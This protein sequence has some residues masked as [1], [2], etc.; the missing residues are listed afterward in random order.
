VKLVIVGGGFAGVKTALELANNKDFEIILISER[1]NFEYHGALY[2]SGTGR[3]PLE[4]VL[5][6]RDIIKHARNVT[7]VQDRIVGLD[8][9]K[10]RIVSETG[11]IYG[12]DKLVLALGNVV[13]YFG[14]DGMEQAAMSLDTI[15]NTIALRHRLVELV[16]S[17]QPRLDVAIVGAGPAGVELAGELQHFAHLIA[18]KYKLSPKKIHV[19]L[20]EGASRVLP[21]LRPEAS[22]KA[23]KRL[24]SLG[25]KVLLNTQLNSCQPGKVCLDSGDL[26]ADVIVW[27]AGGR[28]PGFY[29][30]H[31]HIFQ[32][33]RGHV[34]V[35][36]YLRA[37]G[38]QNIYVIGDNAATPYA[39]MAQTA[40]HD[41][42]F[43]AR[44]LI[45]ELGGGLPFWY[46]AHMPMYAVPIGPN[47]AI[48]QTP[49]RVLSGRR[50]WFVRRRADL[51]IYRNF[52]PYKEAIKTWRK[53]N[54]LADF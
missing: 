1:P 38:N 3:S 43:V 28:A 27:T 54:R 33:E 20:I 21:G 18:D 29:I 52:K 11:N 13:N 24:H 31:Q 25:V 5:P 47:W 50:A 14:I 35:D 32:M 23:H 2:R 40:L 51:A 37:A 6:I 9:T 53:G 44:N 48:L 10:Q 42:K 36:Q 4:V 30:E 17:G 22:V 12:Y 16:R 19:V 41:A 45:R 34:K 49:R 46:R 8:A 26:N 15:A 39:G 7:F